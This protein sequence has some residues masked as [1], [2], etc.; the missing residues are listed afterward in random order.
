MDYCHITIPFKNKMFKVFNEPFVKFIT[1]KL[2]YV[3]LKD[4]QDLLT[5]AT[6]MKLDFIDFVFELMIKY[7]ESKGMENYVILEEIIEVLNFTL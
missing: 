4:E 3:N 2:P 7:I 6:E 1:K 5:H